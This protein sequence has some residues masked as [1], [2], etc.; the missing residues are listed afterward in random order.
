MNEDDTRKGHKAN[1]AQL[2]TTF[3]YDKQKNLLK[4]W[5]QHK[6]LQI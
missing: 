4:A 6:D 1:K 5:K 3:D 2:D